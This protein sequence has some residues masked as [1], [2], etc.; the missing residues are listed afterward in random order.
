[1]PRASQV[2]IK[3]YGFGPDGST[4]VEDI[5]NTYSTGPQKWVSPVDSPEGTN[6]YSL[7]GIS[8]NEKNIIR[9]QFTKDDGFL[10]QIKPFIWN[11]ENYPTTGQWQSIINRRFANTDIPGL[12]PNQQIIFFKNI[13]QFIVDIDRVGFTSLNVGFEDINEFYINLQRI[14]FIFFC[15]AVEYN[16]TY[17]QSDCIFL[18]KLYFLLRKNKYQWLDAVI[19]SVLISKKILL[20]MNLSNL[21]N[22]RYLRRASHIV[23]TG[24]VDP[25][26]FYQSIITFLY[27]KFIDSRKTKKLLHKNK[28]LIMNKFINEFEP[29][30]SFYV[31][32]QKSGHFGSKNREDT[33]YFSKIIINIL[34]ENDITY[35]LA[36]QAGYLSKY[37]TVE[38]HN[39]HKKQVADPDSPVVKSGFIK[40][41]TDPRGLPAINDNELIYDYEFPEK[42]I[43]EIYTYLKKLNYINIQAF[44]D[45]LTQ[46]YNTDPS[47]GIQ[48]VDIDNFLRELSNKNIHF[49]EKKRPLRYRGGK[50]KTIKRKNYRKKKTLKLRH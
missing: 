44:T 16:F 39:E 8:D 11:P 21:S 35:I 18:N 31:L 49:K 14:T 47:S 27:I 13:K 24:G 23:V 12:T 38:S 22:N 19:L 33:D 46:N 48:T 32:M 9:E 36:L 10:H 7:L 42:K 2:I 15:L 26:L 6:F 41:I 20:D 3:R 45:A 4:S 50:K 29:A 5:P 40:Y 25:N 28:G 1:M 34:K 17:N 43:N 37:L 30:I